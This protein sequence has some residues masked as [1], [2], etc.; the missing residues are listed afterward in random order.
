MKKEE[1][2]ENGKREGEWVYVLVGENK[3]EDIAK[4]EMK[5]S[6]KKQ[7]KRGKQRETKIMYIL[8]CV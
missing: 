8:R 5:E 1:R 2:E 7:N 6:V 3:L 4:K